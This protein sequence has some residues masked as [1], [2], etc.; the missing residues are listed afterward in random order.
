MT[1][2][3][4]ST[5]ANLYYCLV[6]LILFGGTF[7][8]RTLSL[9]Y[10]VPNKSMTPSQLTGHFGPVESGTILSLVKIW[11]NTITHRNLVK[12][13][14]PHFFQSLIPIWYFWLVL[15]GIFLIFTILIPKEN[16]VGNFG[17]V[18]LAGTPFSLKRGHWPP[19]QCILAPFLRNIGGPTK[20]FKKGVLAKL[21]A[22]QKLSQ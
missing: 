19:F 5:L 10:D 13:C 7:I 22:R 21:S 12:Y 8:W 3:P 16:L 2:S 15:V 1:F 18:N 14:I 6:Q 11:Y 20:L 9:P 17:T 4:K